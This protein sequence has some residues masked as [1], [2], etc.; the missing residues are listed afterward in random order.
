MK[1]ILLKDIKGL[2][3]T[4]EVK[5]VAEGYA[6]N[7]LFPQNLAVIAT[8]TVLRTI[9]A[10]QKIKLEKEKKQKKQAEELINKLKGLKIEIRVKSDEKGTLFA[11]IGEKQ[12]NEELKKRGYNFKNNQ[13][14]IKEPIKK[15]GDYEIGIDLGF[16]LEVKVK[17]RV[18]GLAEK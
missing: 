16:E 17:V 6:R 1:V 15:I 11:A 12:I 8:E 5:E 3:K 4:D 13:I 9:Q 14:K 10:K 7:F 18:E 2:G